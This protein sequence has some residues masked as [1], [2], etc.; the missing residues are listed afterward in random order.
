MVKLD[1]LLTGLKAAER[2]SVARALN[3]LDDTRPR[4]R[5]LAAELLKQLPAPQDLVQLTGRR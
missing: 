5:E 3:I 4:S 1:E 2:R